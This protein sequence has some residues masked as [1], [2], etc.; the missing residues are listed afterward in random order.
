[1]QWKTRTCA[2]S[3]NSNKTRWYLI[4]WSVQGSVFAFQDHRRLALD[5]VASTPKVMECEWKAG[6]Q[7][8]S[9]ALSELVAKIP[10][11]SVETGSGSPNVTFGVAIV[12]NSDLQ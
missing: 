11:S 9:C 7:V 1:M 10:S 2:V 5:A 4:C 8:Q 6:K 12:G 3:V